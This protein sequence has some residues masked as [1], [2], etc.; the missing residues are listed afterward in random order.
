M[1]VK[2][3]RLNLLNVILILSELISIIFLLMMFSIYYHFVQVASF[4][5]QVILTIIVCATTSLWILIECLPL[6]LRKELQRHEKQRV[7]K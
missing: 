7:K 2:K 3:K 6:W 5:V 1:K 4:S